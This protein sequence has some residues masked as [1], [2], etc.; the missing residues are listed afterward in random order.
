MNAIA[1]P[2]DEP[3]I[4]PKADRAWSEPT[5]RYVRERS[6]PPSALEVANVQSRLHFIGELG[7]AITEAAEEEWGKTLDYAAVSEAISRVEA[8]LKIMP[9]NFPLPFPAVSPEGHLT[10]EWSKSSSLSL[11]VSVGNVGPL[12]F[13]AYVRGERLHGA[14]DFTGDEIPKGFEAAAQM[15]WR[16]N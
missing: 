15:W 14:C 6:E 9:Q 5:L 3:Y 7:E 16:A 10:L 12:Y 8:L 1:I 11:V 13:A 2:Y 4:R